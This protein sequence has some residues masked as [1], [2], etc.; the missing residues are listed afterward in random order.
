MRKKILFLIIIAAFGWSFKAKIDRIKIQEIKLE[1]P[2]NMPA[3]KY[4]DFS[5]TRRC[6]SG[7]C[8]SSGLK[9]N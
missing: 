5:E 3:V 6:Y 7:L 1:T 8:S 9:H 2:F 4:P